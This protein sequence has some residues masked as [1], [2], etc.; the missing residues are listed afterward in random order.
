MRL[1]RKKVGRRVRRKIGR[2]RVGRR[3]KNGKGEKG[4]DIYNFPA[5]GGGEGRRQ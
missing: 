5:W 1:R 3:R 2:R 4:G